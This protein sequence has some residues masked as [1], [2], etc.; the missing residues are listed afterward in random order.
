[1]LLY[2]FKC[3]ILLY[4]D[5]QGAEMSEVIKIRISEETKK[6]LQEIASKEYRTF[7][8]QCRLILDKWVGSNFPKDPTGGPNA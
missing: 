2:V 7:A 6:A 5:Q 8:E 1:M 3:G 4:M